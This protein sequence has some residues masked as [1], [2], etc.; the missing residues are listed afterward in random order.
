MGLGTADRGA[1]GEGGGRGV[2]GLSKR[3]MRLNKKS[4]K[5]AS[6]NAAEQNIWSGAAPGTD[7]NR[8]MGTA[9]C[10]QDHIFDC[11]QEFLTESR[12][13]ASAPIGTGLWKRLDWIRL[14]LF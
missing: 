7:L 6:W 5:A 2:Q 3:T 1:R 10:R 11:L 9:P 13:M 4:H 8:K 14:E 12:Y